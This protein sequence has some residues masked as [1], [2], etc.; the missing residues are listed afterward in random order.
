[1]INEWIIDRKCLSGRKIE[2]LLGKKFVF[3]WKYFVGFRVY[4]IDIRKT[5]GIRYKCVLIRKLRLGWQ[6][7]RKCGYFQFNISLCITFLVAVLVF[8][9]LIR[10]FEKFLGI[11]S[12]F[13]G[14]CFC[15]CPWHIQKG[16]HS[17]FYNFVHWDSH[18]FS[19]LKLTDMILHYTGLFCWLVRVLSGDLLCALN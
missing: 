9:W 4:F 8:S 12:V 13:A 17:Y 3:R 14:I 19:L 1:M 6:K 7:E 5:V 10:N 18:I 2:K 16:P 15:S 11:L